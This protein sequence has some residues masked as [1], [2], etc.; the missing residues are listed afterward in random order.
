MTPDEN[1]QTRRRHADD[2]RH[3]TETFKLSPDPLFID[4]VRDIVGLPNESTT[5]DTRRPEPCSSIRVGDPELNTG[6]ADTGFARCISA[7]WFS[8]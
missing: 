8:G 5:R 3:R 7:V 2:F 1:R 4:K 6:A